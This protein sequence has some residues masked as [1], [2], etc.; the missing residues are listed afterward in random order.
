MTS[1]KS[2][3]L[4]TTGKTHLFHTLFTPETA[5]VKAT[6]LI[7]HGMQEHSGRYTEIAEY[8][9]NRGFAVLT[10]DH[11]GHGQSV[12]DKK[13]IGFFQLDQPDEKLISDAEAMTE[14]LHKQYPDIPHF[15]LGHSMGSFVTRCLLQ[16]AGNK[17]AGA[18]IV[19]TGGPLSGISFIKGYLSLANKIAP[20]HPT[21]LNNLFNL[22]NNSHFKKDKD[23][24]D[25]SWLSVNPDNRKAFTE[26]ELCG[27]PFTNNAFYAL[28]S[29]YKKATSGNWAASISKSFP[30]LFVSGQD[31]PIGDFGKGVTRTIKQL[32]QNGFK[33]VD[34]KIYLGMRHE[35]LNEEIKEKVFN[36]IYQWIARHL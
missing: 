32:K 2:S 24:S 25:T 5:P 31:D 11:L 27:I 4:P 20:Y 19:G 34:I 7:I 3:Y 10:Y 13:D 26:D 29:I 21:F 28:F 22:V 12:K 35:I 18:V 36:D 6:L 1:Q 23:F 9:A 16:R 15:V 30:F 33:D 14:Y 17:F 8:F